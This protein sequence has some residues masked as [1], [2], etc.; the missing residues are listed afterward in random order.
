MSA[1]NEWFGYY[2]AIFTHLRETYG[3]NELEAYFDY[4]VKNAY[5]DVI[6]LYRDGGLAKI[7][8]RYVTNFK[9][10]GDDS[11]AKAEIIGNELKIEVKCPAF[12]NAPTVKH[13]DKH[14]GPF[15][16]DCCKSL[17]GKILDAAGYTLK[18][19]GGCGNCIFNVTKK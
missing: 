4:L 10:D 16:C 11:S 7:A 14:V 3:D 19:E 1:I 9:K 8:D 12:Y 13:P 2:N 5:D 15:F 17:N 18:I 6:P